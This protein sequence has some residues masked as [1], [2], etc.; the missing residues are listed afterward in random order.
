[1]IIDKG[2]RIIARLRQGFGEV[3]YGQNVRFYVKNDV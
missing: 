3:A 2:L 1:M